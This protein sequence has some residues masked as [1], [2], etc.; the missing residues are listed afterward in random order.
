MNYLYASL[1]ALALL[2]ASF[3]AGRASKKPEIITVAEAPIEKV[4]EVTR[5]LT[6]K[7]TIKTVV[8]WAKTSPDGTKEE[9]ETSKE[10]TKDSSDTSGIKDAVQVADGSTSSSGPVVVVPPGSEVKVNGDTPLAS[11]DNYYVGLLGGVLLTKESRG[12]IVGASVVKR[13]VGP[14]WI[15]GF[16]LFGKQTQIVGIGTGVSWK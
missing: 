3:F 11:R 8:K 14:V 13:V 4:R 10:E 9:T 6:A 7:D 16:G 12:Y 2:T 1:A 15:Q 5:T